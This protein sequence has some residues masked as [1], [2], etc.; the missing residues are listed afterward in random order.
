MR[1][2]YVAIFLAAVACI[3]EFVVKFVKVNRANVTAL[4]WTRALDWHCYQGA[5]GLRPTLCGKQGNYT[6]Y[7]GP[8]ISPALEAELMKDVI[9]VA[10]V[11]IVRS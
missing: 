3:T 2:L 7:D 8:N 4:L 6:Q 5:G 9:I 11:N 10:A 1:L